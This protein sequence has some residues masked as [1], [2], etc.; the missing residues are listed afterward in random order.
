MP[1]LQISYICHDQDGN[2]LETVGVPPEEAPFVELGRGELLPE[3]ER[4]LAHMKAGETREVV[5]KPR[6]A[7]G[8]VDESLFFEVPIEALSLDEEPEIGMTVELSEDGEECNPGTIVE[9]NDD[10]VLV[11]C[12]H[13]LAGKTLRFELT[14]FSISNE[15][16]AMSNEQ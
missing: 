15:Q 14:L 12:N 5:L 11:D 3:L 6:Q 16:L 8:A 1:R 9:I 7:F 10:T 4:Q 13:P 2:L